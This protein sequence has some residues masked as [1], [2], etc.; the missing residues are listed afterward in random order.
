MRFFLAKNQKTLNV[1]K[2]RNYDE[3]RVFFREKK[4]F[5][6]FLKL[7]LEKWEDTKHTGGSRPSC[8]KF[9]QKGSKMYLNFYRKPQEPSVHGLVVTFKNIGVRN[10]VMDYLKP[11]F[12]DY[13]VCTLYE[14]SRAHQVLARNFRFKVRIKINFFPSHN[15]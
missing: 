11:T 7:Y 9:N 12:Y 10:H 15:F 2:I 14:G 8:F 3:E 4:T 1:R 5:S 13:R 6:S